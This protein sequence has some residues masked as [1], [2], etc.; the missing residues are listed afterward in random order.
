MLPKR[1]RRL[2]KP[3]LLLDHWVQMACATCSLLLDKANQYLWG[4]EAEEKEE[5]KEEDET[6][7]EAEEEADEEE[8]AAGRGLGL[9]RIFISLRAQ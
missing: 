7:E 9:I 5:T 3:V 6:E 8:E 4:R 1:S 2:A